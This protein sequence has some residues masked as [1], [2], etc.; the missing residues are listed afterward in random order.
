MVVEKAT[1]PHQIIT[2]I[3]LHHNEHINYQAAHEAKTTILQAHFEEQARQY[4]LL[5]SY[6]QTLRQCCPDVYFNLQVLQDEPEIPS[7]NGITTAVDAF[8]PVF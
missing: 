4:Q 6:L 3:R 2:T 8:S 7:E 5:P 1:T